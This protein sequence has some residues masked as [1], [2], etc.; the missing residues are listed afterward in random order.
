MP[1]FEHSR[2]QIVVLE[3]KFE[4]D[5]IAKLEALKYRFRPAIR[6][7]LSL[8]A[9]FRQQFEVLDRVRSIAAVCA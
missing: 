9:N 2:G 5:F 7:R 3:N 6:D 1:C 4:R 8:E